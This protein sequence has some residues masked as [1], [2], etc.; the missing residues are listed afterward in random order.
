MENKQDSISALDEALLKEFSTPDE[1]ADEPKDEEEDV[2]DESED[3]EDDETEDE[4]D[5]SE[6]E[7]DDEEIDDEPSEEVKETLKKEKQKNFEFG[8]LRK[9]K[10]EAQRLA[11]E[12][13]SKVEDQGEIL[14]RLM[15]EAG[16]DKYDEFKQ[17]VTTQLK[18]KEM[19]EKGYSEEQFEELETMRKKM[20]EF[21]K[22]ETESHKNEM[23]QRAKS[24]DDTVRSFAETNKMG[25]D[26]VKKIYDSLEQ[27][28]YNLDI[29][30]AQPKPEILI[31]GV[32]SDYLKDSSVQEYLNKKA[33]RKTVDSGK[34]RSE[35]LE[36]TLE[37]LQ[38]EEIKRDLDAYKKRRGY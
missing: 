22:K 27:A 25:K 1:P 16:Y 9:E 8:R 15:K 36:D 5:D 38:D 29:L 35:K 18:Q 34:I 12:L 17:A 20:Q 37:S 30:L 26:G 23:A 7:P 11:S 24:F 2:V 4:D 6:D 31:K 14:N 3:T 19:K 32:M 10:A 13:A 33:T 21:E 28:G